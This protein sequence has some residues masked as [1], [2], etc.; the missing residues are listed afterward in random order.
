MRLTMPAI[1]LVL[2]MGTI[3]HTA[4][5]TFQ[6]VQAAQT[7][8]LSDGIL[9]R[10]PADWREPAGALIRATAEEQQRFLTVAEEVLRQNLAR[11]LVRSPRADAF[12]RQQVVKDPSPRVR[13]TIVQAIAADRRWIALPDT[14]TLIERV[15]SSD[16]DPAVSLAALETLRRRSDADAEH[17]TQRAHRCGEDR[18]RCRDPRAARTRARAMAQPRTWQHAAGVPDVRRRQS[19]ASSPKTRT[20]V[21]W[22]SAISAT[23]P[24][25]RRPPQS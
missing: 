11:L 13:T 8:P 21:S 17:A 12:L 3:A 5:V 23:D 14:A 24:R 19:F 6:P 22:R 15:V 10:L 20:F 25:R 16:A 4:A 7:I 18:R 2:S 9:S 1:A